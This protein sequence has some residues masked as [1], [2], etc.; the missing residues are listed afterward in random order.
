MRLVNKEVVMSKKVVFSGIALVIGL[1]MITTAF[2]AY[3]FYVLKLSTKAKVM[4]WSWIEKSARSV[5]GV[6]KVE[7][8]KGKGT[9][10]IFCKEK[11]T[12]KI[13]QGVEGK[14]KTKGIEGQKIGGVQNVPG[15]AFPKVET[16]TSPAGKTGGAFP[17]VE[18]QTSPAGKIR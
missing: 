8:D 13:Q 2:A 1:F 3:E 5:P 12:D 15:G 16:Q 18:T 10:S 14:L 11:C 9:I 6:E 17:K 4:E 7:V